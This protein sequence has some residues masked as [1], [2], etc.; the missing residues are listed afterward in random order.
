MSEPGILELLSEVGNRFKVSSEIIDGSNC[1]ILC[2]NTP[3]DMDSGSPD[4]R[5][6][7]E[8]ALHVSEHIKKGDMVI[9]RSTVP[10]GISREVGN[11]ISGRCGLEPGKDFSLAAAPERTVEGRA[12]QEISALPQIV[13]GID[14]SSAKR[15]VELFDNL[16]SNVRIV[17]S[18]EAAELV[19]LL[20]NS[21]RYVSFA[22]ANEFGLACEE[23]GLDAYEV[24]EAANWKYPR[25]Q[26]KLPGAG[27]G[28]GCL[29]KDARMLSFACNQ[30]GLVPRMLRAATETNE[31]MPIRIF[32]RIK[33]FHSQN[34]L[35]L[36]GSR[37]LIMGFAFKGSPE[38]SDVR[39]SP[40][41]PLVTLL[42]NHK[43]IVYGHDPALSREMIEE[44]KAF[45]CNPSSIDNLRCVV[46]M[47]NNE[48]FGRVDLRDLAERITRPGLVADGWRMLDGRL[49]RD[50]GVEYYCVGV[51]TT[52]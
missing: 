29:P 35:P 50:L 32:E 7:K 46:V 28:G 6:L 15:A 3:V 25:N 14:S 49:L 31:R 5:F 27:V 24:I 4:M 48:N 41:E 19:K 37:I 52:S 33:T 13:G 11:W 34:G 22:L 1:Y 12:L 45:P 36:Q 18:L 44:M 23:L 9:L 2:V 47:N 30:R 17:S 40:T 10:P 42:E 43:A 16:T 51:G 38:V 21:F 39:H 8:A 26:I 20:D